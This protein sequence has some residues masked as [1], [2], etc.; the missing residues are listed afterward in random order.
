M[1]SLNFASTEMNRENLKSLL[2]R[3]KDLTLDIEKEIYSDSQ[4]TLN[5]DYN[6]VIKYYNQEETTDGHEKENY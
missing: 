3:L 6:E 1:L 5:L 4:Q 2:K